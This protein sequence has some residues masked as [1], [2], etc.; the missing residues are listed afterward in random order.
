M[1]MTTD[2]LYF[3]PRLQVVNDAQIARIHMATL[4][5]LERTGVKITHPKALEILAGAGARVNG[6][7]VRIPGWLVEDAIRKAP[8]RI[9]LATRTGERTVFLERDKSFFGPSL[10]CVDYMDPGTH[11]RSRFVSENVKATAALCD[12]L[13]NFQWCM[14]IGMADDVP[15]DIADRVIARNV[16]ENCTKPLVFCCKDTNSIKDTYE[17]ALL[18]CGGKETFDQAPTIVHYSEPISPLVYF[19]PAIDKVIY[20]AEN[21]IP[22]DQ[23]PGAPVLRQFPSHL[24]RCPG[25]GQRRI[26]QR[27]GGP[28]IGQPRRPLYL[29][30]LHHHHGHAL[31]HLLIRRRGDEPDDRRHGPDGPELRTALFRHGRRDRRKIL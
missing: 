28:S 2:E 6:D 16:F 30:R 15:A 22:L 19:D 11:K 24:R 17:M 12:A 14:T 7:R 31:D 3:K 23:L 4:D 26:P 29:R 10:D 8:S 21:R 13:P 5:V 18:L 27:P 20:C 25:P 1:G 9:V